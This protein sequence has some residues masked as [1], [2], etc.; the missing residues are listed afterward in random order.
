MSRLQEGGKEVADGMISFMSMS[1][2]FIT[3]CKLR[4]D[5]DGNL[6]DTVKLANI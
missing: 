4:D 2:I 3:S 6:M 5:E 1:L